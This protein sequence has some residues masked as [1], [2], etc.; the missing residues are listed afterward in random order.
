MTHHVIIAAQAGGPEVLDWRPA[1]TTLS[2]GVGELLVATAAVGV[3]FIDTYQR[4]G[5]YPVS[6]PFTPGTEASGTVIEV[7]KGVTDFTVGDRI[8]TCEARATYAERFVVEAHKAVV[9]PEAISLEVAAA[10]PLQSI[11]AHYLHTSASRPEAGDTVLVHAGAGGVGLILTQMLSAKGVTVITTASTVAKREQSLAAG[12]AHAIPYEN[13]DARVRDITRGEGVQVVYDGVGKDTFDQSLA[14]L[15][16]RATLVLFGGASG[17]VPP[18][19][20]QRLSAAGSVSVTRPT[21]GHFL[22]T[23]EERAWRYG[24][25]FDA[26]ERG[27]LTITVGHTFPLEHAAQAHRALEGRATTGKVVLTTGR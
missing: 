1:E 23:P 15:A 25:V 26:I 5:I 3:N 21:L 8:T 2:P 19:D 11:T 22:Q 18:F 12:A 4:S 14:S 16:V 9:V 20:L 17:Q 24:E 6:Y 7:G 13:F 27:S 10:I